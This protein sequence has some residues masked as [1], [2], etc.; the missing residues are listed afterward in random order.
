MIALSQ[1]VLSM[2]GWSENK[3]EILGMCTFVQSLP[4]KLVP[5]L[6][7]YFYFLKNIKWGF[8]F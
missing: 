1:G 7:P 6:V 8:L 2:Y 3:A 5:S 4:Y